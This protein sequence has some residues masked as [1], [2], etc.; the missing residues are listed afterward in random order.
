M[1]VEE[2]KRQGEVMH[3]MQYKDHDLQQVAVTANDKRYQQL[4]KVL[5]EYEDVNGALITVLHQA[6]KIFGYLPRE[7]QIYT[8]ERLGI[9]FAE[10]YGVVSFYALFSVKPRGEYTIEICLGTACYVKGAKKIL[11]TLQKELGIEPGETTKDGK[12]TLETT[13]CLGACSLAPMIK[14]GDDIHGNLTIEKVVELLK[15]YR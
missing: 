13:R 5:D 8:A 14:V 15:Q 12:F 4:D 9:P 6:Q 11:D 7:V 3:E 1:R 10:V 2:Q